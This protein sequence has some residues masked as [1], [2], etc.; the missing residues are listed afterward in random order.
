MKFQFLGA[1]YTLRV[2]LLC[3]FMLILASTH[4]AVVSAQQAEAD[5]TKL[6]KIEGAKA[7]Q[8]GVTL[9]KDA[10]EDALSLE[11]AKAIAKQRLQDSLAVFGEPN[12]DLAFI[13]RDAEYRSSSRVFPTATENDGRKLIN[14][15][16]RPSTFDDDRTWSQ[17]NSWWLGQA[18]P[19]LLTPHQK[20]GLCILVEGKGKLPD[21]V[22]KVLSESKPMPLDDDLKPLELRPRRAGKDLELWNARVSGTRALVCWYWLSKAGG[23]E[24]PADFPKM[25]LPDIASAF[26]KARS[27]HM[28]DAE[29]EN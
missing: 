23:A 10:T 3:A 26:E 5:K 18:Y 11:K 9:H 7:M 1:K 16:V 8:T 22:L 20:E 27:A 4:A 17:I 2:Q 29:K 19:R 25:K 12:F 15:H 21:R 14:I 6:S 24:S 28:P 13:V